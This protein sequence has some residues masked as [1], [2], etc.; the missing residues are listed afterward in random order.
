MTVRALI[1]KLL[2]ATTE[3]EIKEAGGDPLDTE[4]VINGYYLRDYT[5]CRLYNSKPV[6]ALF[7]DEDGLERRERERGRPND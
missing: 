3:S 1:Q 7:V 6:I 2:M 4:V 5:Q